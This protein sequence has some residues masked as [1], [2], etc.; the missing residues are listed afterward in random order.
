[1]TSSSDTAASKSATSEVGGSLDDVRASD[2]RI[3]GRRGQATRARL[4]ESTLTM[5]ERGAYRDL[6]VVDIAREAGTSPATFYQ[7]FP[8][9]E[10]AIAV[11][12]EEMAA[13]GTD[14]LPGFVAGLSWA[15]EDAYASADKV[16][17]AFFG[18]WDEH[19]P[20]MRVMDLTASEGDQRI[21]RVRVGLMNDFARALAVVV[22]DHV[23][24]GALAPDT[25]CDAT[26]AA[27]VT[28]LVNVAIQRNQYAYFGLKAQE[29]D[30]AVVKM[31]YAVITGLPLPR[32]GQ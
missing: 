26:A 22:D 18:F 23:R 30:D 31:A 9:V 24:R 27:V 28:L 15:A 20:L 14:R 21:R 6:K 29:I 19:R 8:D 25:N 7:Y 5:L 3:P 1:M 13:D 16:V 10:A 11:L 2:G 12:A 4:L 32:S 17:Q